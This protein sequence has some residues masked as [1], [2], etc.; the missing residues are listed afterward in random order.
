MEPG[1]D[2]D[3]VEVQKKAAAGD[4]ESMFQLGFIAAISGE[5]KKAL[6]WFEESSAK[7]FAIAK[8]HLAQMLL[9]GRGCKKDE[10]R[11]IELLEAG[12]A[13]DEPGCLVSLGDLY[14]GKSQFD[15]AEMYYKKAIECGNTEEQKHAAYNLAMMYHTESSVRNLEAATQW[16]ERAANLG[17]VDAQ[18]NFAC[19]L[20]QG[21]G[22]PRDDVAARLWFARAAASGHNDALMNL[23]LMVQ[24]G[25][26]GAR[27]ATRA[28]ALASVAKARDVDDAA[29]L[30]A[31][32][33]LQKQGQEQEQQQ[34]E[35]KAEQQGA[36]QE[37]SQCSTLSCGKT[38]A[39]ADF[40]LCSRCKQSCYCSR[41]CQILDWKEFGH[42]FVCGK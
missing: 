26:G 33:Q 20:H 10:R 3:I 24:D 4:A 9:E 30:L 18:Y 36:Q 1:E 25:V 21:D 17:Q 8:L 5:N 28:V 41:D 42:K 16:L 40:K 7:G 38:G 27:D 2:F 19:M 32:L 35:Q 12:A 39:T 15:K 22:V 34:K 37:Q 11:A 6:T 29:D 23:V 31:K 13:A 14:Q